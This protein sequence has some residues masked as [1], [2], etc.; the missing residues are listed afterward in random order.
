MISLKHLHLFVVNPLFKYLAEDRPGDD[1]STGKYAGLNTIAAKR[2]VLGTM[3]VE[4]G[5]LA[6]DQ[7]TS[8]NDVTLGP[9]IGLYQIEPS[10]MEDIILWLDRHPVLRHRVLSTLGDYPVDRRVQLAS[11]LM[12]A[13]AVCRMLYFRAPEPLPIADDLDGL[14]AY[15]KKYYNT[16]KGAGTISGFKTRAKQVMEIKDDV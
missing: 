13:T 12:F 15:W 4:T 11:N 14:A 10:T 9:A 2:M 16:E 5:G 3:L 7:I 8:Q 6:L 1:G